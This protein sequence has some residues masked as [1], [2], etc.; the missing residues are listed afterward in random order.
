MR[1]ARVLTRGKAKKPSS[2]S[3]PLVLLIASGLAILGAFTF[4]SVLVAGADQHD[5]PAPDHLLSEANKGGFHSAFA[6]VPSSLMPRAVAAARGFV[7]GVH[8]VEM[9]WPERWEIDGTRVSCML[10]E[11][12]HSEYGRRGAN[13]RI[14][15]LLQTG[16][17]LELPQLWEEALQEQFAEHVD[18]ERRM[19]NDPTLKF[20]PLCLTL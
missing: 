11:H 12:F 14:D 7:P 20:T 3:L 19:R 13:D 17:R 9:K 15:A 4:S 10:V 6:L 2:S 5:A 16:R 1:N 18:R 8:E